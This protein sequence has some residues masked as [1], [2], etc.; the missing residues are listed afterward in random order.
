[1]RCHPRPQLNNDVRDRG[2][3]PV[4]AV[5]FRVFSALVTLSTESPLFPYVH[6]DV[7]GG[8]LN[9]VPM[10]GPRGQKKTEQNNTERTIQIER[11]V[12]CNSLEMETP[13]SPSESKAM[14]A[15]STEGVREMHASSAV[16]QEV[17]ELFD[18]LR[19]RL[20]RYLSGFSV[21]VQDSEDIIQ[22]TFLALFQHL[23]RGKSR[24]H[25]R[26]WLFRV[27]HNLALKHRRSQRNSKHDPESMR[28]AED[29]V[30][31]PAP[32]PEDEFA[33]N[34]L[35]G[36]IMA[37]LEALP[38]QNRWC[39]YLRAEGLRYREIAE[40]LDMSL[41]SVANCLERSL[42]HLARAVER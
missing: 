20:L 18:Q 12:V 23:R 10:C 5:L 2:L 32:N 14:I 13:G 15:L 17:V 37:V 26:G 1:M 30:I 6:N 4:P 7:A 9:G 16:E 35:R 33:T 3:D 36:R 42:A 38:E 19:D 31:N 25:L 34:Q 27:A 11:I 8:D 40:I 21:P 39:L 29:L 28:A 22:E 24:Q 41:G